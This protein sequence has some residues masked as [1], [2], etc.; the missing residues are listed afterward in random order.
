MATVFQGTTSHPRSE[1]SGPNDTA[2]Q[3]HWWRTTGNNI[4]IESV[5]SGGRGRTVAN[6]PTSIGTA[7]NSA[8]FPLQADGSNPVVNA[9]SINGGRQVLPNSDWM[10]GSENWEDARNGTPL[11]FIM[12]PINRTS[13]AL[14]VFGTGG[15]FGNDGI[16]NRVNGQRLHMSDIR[17]G[18]GGMDLDMA[19]TSLN[20]SEGFRNG[21]RWRHVHAGRTDLRSNRV[22]IGYTGA[23]GSVPQ[24]I[25]AVFR[26][27]QIFDVRSWLRSKG[28][29]NFGLLLDGG[30]SAQARNRAGNQ[31]QTILSSTR[32]VPV[33]LSMS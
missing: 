17:W 3:I 27:C 25:V 29:T 18:I 8:F 31:S 4:A 22:A 12:D 26:D 33:V 16:L 20:S 24:Y 13:N 2:V 19:N 7:V 11:D 32:N 5:V 15:A 1:P 23:V 9:F 21:F 10:N 28:V 6:W 14:L 30:A